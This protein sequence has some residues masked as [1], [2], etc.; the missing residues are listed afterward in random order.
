[1]ATGWPKQALASSEVSTS[2]AVPAASTRP[3]RQQQGVRGAGGQFLQVMGHQD[4]GQAGLTRA[5]L[6]DADQELLAA[7]HVQAGRG[8]VQQQQLRLRHQAARDE[9]PAALTL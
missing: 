5:Q 6:V 9:R 8:L 1:M 7:G 2:A 3:E 4:G